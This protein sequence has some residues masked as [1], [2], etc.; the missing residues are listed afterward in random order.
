MTFDRRRIYIY[1]WVCFY[2]KLS[3]S[4]FQREQWT[5]LVR[6]R[7]HFMVASPQH[8]PQS[9]T[10][11]SNHPKSRTF[12][13]P[14][15]FPIY[16]HNKS[17]PRASRRGEINYMC[18]IGRVSASKLRTNP[19]DRSRPSSTAS[20]GGPPRRRRHTHHNVSRDATRY[21]RYH[22]A[23]LQTRY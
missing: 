20:W 11:H 22:L 12:G 4:S 5:F 23:N 3:K 13:T 14:L 19:S 8:P 1:V 2:I 15:Y 7:E 16:T 17:Q 18:K 10:I 9:C 6:W 21:I